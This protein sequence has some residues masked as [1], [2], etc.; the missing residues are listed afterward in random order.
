MT[1]G[2]PGCGKSTYLKEHY[3]NVFNYKK[4]CLETDRKTNIDEYISSTADDEY[5]VIAADDIK[6]CLNGYSPEHPELVHEQSVQLARAYIF[7]LLDS[8]KFN[9]NVIMDG[10]GINSNYTK[11]IITAIR[12]A[13]QGTKITCLFFD[14]PIDVCIERVNSRDR[15]IPIEAFFQKNLKLAKCLEYYQQVVDEYIRV[16]YYTNKYIFLDMDGTIVSYRKGKLDMDGNTDMV[17]SHLFINANPVRYIIDY[18]KSN[19]DMNNVYII[20]AVANDFVLQEKI[21]WIKKYFPEFHMENFHWCGNKQY[22]HVYLKHLSIR[23]KMN[24]KDM[25]IIDDLHETLRKC[26]AMGMNAI[27][28]SNI[29]ALTDKYSTLG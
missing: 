18:V 28:P 10:G 20:T 4:F 12:D 16:D 24:I 5:V 17:N 1:V 2:L 19:F 8:D 27:H 23:E 7:S 29:E 6:E 15:K 11:S 3:N 22:K 9:G 25:T 21:D 13:N 26:T 14:T